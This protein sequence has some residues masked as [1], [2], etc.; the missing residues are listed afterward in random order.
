MDPNDPDG[1]DWPGEADEGPSRSQ[2]KREYQALQ[3]MAER[4]LALPRADLERLELGEATRAAI[5]ETDR[6]SDRR[7]L[8]RHTKRLGKLL[9]RED[10]DAVAALLDEKTGLSREAAARH[11]RLE[12]WRERLIGEGDEALGELLDEHPQL[13]RQQ[14]RSLVRAAQRDRE[15]GRP[16]AARRLFRFLREAL[17]DEA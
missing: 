12:H 6:I 3:D 11:H 15:R 16:D 8:R 2:V 17:G 10:T 14:L 4:L 7:A 13:D 1:E 5:A 9:A